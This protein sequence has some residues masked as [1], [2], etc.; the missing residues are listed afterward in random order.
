MHAARAA[1]LFFLVQL[2][3]FLIY[4]INVVVDFVEAGS[5]QTSRLM[6][7]LNECDS[8]FITTFAI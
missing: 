2:M 3:R 6:Q 8:A 4:D 7:F 5:S 1:R